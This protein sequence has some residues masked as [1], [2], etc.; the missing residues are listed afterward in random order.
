M[1]DQVWRARILQRP[2]WPRLARLVSTIAEA[3]AAKK[4]LWLAT[5]RYVRQAAAP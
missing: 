2:N 1:L 5:A 4:T 3:L